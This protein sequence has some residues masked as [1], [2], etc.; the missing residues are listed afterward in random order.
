MPVVPNRALVVTRFAV[1][2][3]DAER[4]LARS[5]EALEALAGRPG[6]VRG[7]LG[8]GLDDPAAW[9]LVTEWDGVGS[10]RR[11]LSNYDVKVRASPLLAQARDE[12][13]GFEVLLAADGGGE[14]TTTRSDRA[15]DADSTGPGCTVPAAERRETR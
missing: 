2:E 8:R 7:H 9:L 5:R 10:Y 3:Q 12:P 11:A 4:F 6:Y 15:A 13:T 1:P 14:I